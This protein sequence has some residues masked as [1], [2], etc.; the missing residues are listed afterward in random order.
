MECPSTGVDQMF[1]SLLDQNCE[2]SGWGDRA[3]AKCHS[4]LIMGRAHTT[5]MI[6]HWPCWVPSLGWGGPCHHKV[7]LLSPFSILCSLGRKS[8]CEA[9]TWVESYVNLPGWHGIYINYLDSSAKEIDLFSL[10]LFIYSILYLHQCGLMDS[11]FILWVI[12]QIQCSNFVAQIVLALVTGSS[13]AALV[14]S[15]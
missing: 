3:E 8:L 7:T 12:I 14:S 9:H 4:H 10:D 15:W 11:Y 2:F 13:L 1:F 6:Y 5:T